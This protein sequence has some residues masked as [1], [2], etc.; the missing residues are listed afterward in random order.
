M[1][2]K[3]KFAVIG[4]GHIGKRHAAVIANN[5]ECELAALCDT[6]AKERPDPGDHNISFY[7]S[8]D[9]LLQSGIPLD[10][11]CI[12]TPNGCHEEQALKVLKAGYHVVIEKPMALTKEGCERIM[13]ESMRQQ[14]QVFCVMQ[15]RYSPPAVWLKE[16][17]HKKI[18]GE[19][20][21][22]QVN[23]YWNRD[24]R[25]YTGNTWHGSKESDGGTLF[26]QFSHFIDM[27]FWLFGDIKNISGKLNNFNHAGLT[28]FEDSGF[29]HFDFVHGGAGCLNYSTAVW[30]ENL[31]S[32]M[33]IIAQNGTIKTGGQ[34]MKEVQ[35]CNV[36]D[37]TMP[38]L[39]PAD[40]GSNHHFIIE[41]VVDI[42]KERVPAAT[43]AG[44]GMKVVEIIERIYK[45][46]RVGN[47][48]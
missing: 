40:A 23:C 42:L 43:N 21:I 11:V 44:D 2:N 13:Y 32:T 10:V 7:T 26:T 37:Y 39:A 4:C 12:A 35:Y 20:Y 48:E 33:T 18:L 17:L 8:I 22:V 5:E 27:L 38:E 1:E 47:G 41:N 34:Y 28:D 24:E 46:G 14:K 45:V 29:I 9:E 25:Y 15:N 16:V 19:I 36:K 30:N 6:I 3:I 31:E